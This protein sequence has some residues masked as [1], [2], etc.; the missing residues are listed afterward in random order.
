MVSHAAAAAVAA[1]TDGNIVDDVCGGGSVVVFIP[2]VP[3]SPLG[4]PKVVLLLDGAPCEYA[5]IIPL[6]ES[7]V[8]RMLE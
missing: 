1:A 5:F 7:S 4:T 2:L 6:L 3:A 8:L